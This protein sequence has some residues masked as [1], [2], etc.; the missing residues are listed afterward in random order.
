MTLREFFSSAL[1]A[2]G[3][4]IAVLSGG[5]STIWI[6]IL[7]Y[8]DGLRVPDI[9]FHAMVTGIVGGIPFVIGLA[10]IGIG[11]LLRPKKYEG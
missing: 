6:G 9:P 7:L 5:C 4:L 2:T 1:G 10:L 3:I 8:N 11:K